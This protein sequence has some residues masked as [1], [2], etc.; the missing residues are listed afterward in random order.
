M[1]LNARRA[2]KIVRQIPCAAIQLRWFP[3]AKI[4][5]P[6]CQPWMQR[7]PTIAG[8]FCAAAFCR[9]QRA[10]WIFLMVN[11]ITIYKNSS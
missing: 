4:F 2:E 11:K 9:H 5:Q 8:A 3:L 6:L 1:I 10:S 7:E